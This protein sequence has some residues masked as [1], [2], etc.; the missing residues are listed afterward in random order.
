MHN[1]I[2]AWVDTYQQQMLQES[3]W[4][5]QGTGKSQPQPALAHWLLQRQLQSQ[6]VLYVTMQIVHLHTNIWGGKRKREVNMSRACSRLYTIQYSCH[7]S[8]RKCQSSNLHLFMLDSY[9]FKL[10]DHTY[11]HACSQWWCVNKTLN[12]RAGSQSGLTHIL[13]AWKKWNKTWIA[14]LQTNNKKMQ[15]ILPVFPS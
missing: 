11:L 6:D 5:L 14:S 2:N 4:P 1:C 10:I 3:C 9:G 15:H 12:W 8:E 13:N 7:L